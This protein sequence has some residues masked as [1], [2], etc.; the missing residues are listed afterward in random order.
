MDKQ[1]RSHYYLQICKSIV[2]YFFLCIKYTFQFSSATKKERKDYLLKSINAMEKKTSIPFEPIGF[3]ECY[4]GLK[5]SLHMFKQFFNSKN[6]SRRFYLRFSGKNIGK[7]GS[8]NVTISNTP[9]EEVLFDV[10][11]KCGFK[12]VKEELLT[13]ET[14][15]LVEQA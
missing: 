5:Y 4:L 2:R 15:Y 1:P 12:L 14:L 8:E 3:D 7:I 10:I 6:S 13:T 9:N 11:E